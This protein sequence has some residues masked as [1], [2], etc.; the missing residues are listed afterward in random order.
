[1]DSWWCELCRDHFDKDHFDQPYESSDGHVYESGR[2]GEGSEY[3]PYGILLSKERFYPIFRG[4]LEMIADKCEDD[5][6][7]Q[8][9]KEV[10][11]IA[12]STLKRTEIDNGSS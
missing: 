6:R 10:A 9:P 1:M 5:P 7:N 4:I 3:G 12:R 11:K 8:E 2:H